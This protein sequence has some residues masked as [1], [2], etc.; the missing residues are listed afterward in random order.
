[1]QWSVRSTKGWRWNLRTRAREAVSDASPST[2]WRHT[3]APSSGA[4]DASRSF[5]QPWL[6]RACL[7]SVRA[8]ACQR[9]CKRP[10]A[11]SHPNGNVASLQLGRKSTLSLC[12]HG[13]PRVFQG[14]CGRH[15]AGNPA[16]LAFTAHCPAD[17][18]SKDRWTQQT[19]RP[20]C[21]F[22]QGEAVRAGWECRAGARVK[23]CKLRQPSE[24]CK[25][26]APVCQRA[27]EAAC[28]ST[29]R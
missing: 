19:P 11:V 16:F 28:G 3:E 15:C 21:S 29:S 22:L 17:A 1:M 9:H 20:K 7:H 18:S 12:A 27:S 14:A 6:D 26:R 5:C 8:C 4:Q 23:A 2:R 25:L 24:A 13:S 10:A